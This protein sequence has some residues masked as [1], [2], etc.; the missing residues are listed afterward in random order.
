MKYAFVFLVVCIHSILTYGQPLFQFT[1]VVNYSKQQYGAGTQNWVVEQDRFG[2]MYFANNEGVLTYNGNEWQV[3]PLPNNTIVRYIAFGIDGKLYAGGQDELGYYEADRLG[4][5]VFTSL[6]HL[7]NKDDRQFA[8][9]WNILPQGNEVFFRSSSRIFWLHNGEIS[10]FKP[11]SSWTFLGKHGKYIMAHDRSTG[12]FVFKNGRWELAFRSSKLPQDLKITSMAPFKFGSILT[13]EKNGLLRIIGNDIV[14]FFLKGSNI[15][16]KQ[17]FT[18]VLLMENHELL[19]GT[20]DDGIYHVDSVG[21]VLE[22]FSTN[23]GL[24]NN[25][26]KYIFR[27]A[28]KKIW[29]GLEDGISFLNTN[30]YVKFLRPKL[31]N[32]AAG[33]AATIFGEKLYFALANGIYSM[34]INKI[35]DYS[36]DIG[37]LKKLTDGLS[38]KV[39]N[40]QGHLFAGCEDGFFEIKGDRLIPIDRSTGYWVFEYINQNATTMSLATGSYLGVSF[41]QSSSGVYSRQPD[42]VFLNSSSRYLEYDSSQNVVWVSHPYRGIYKISLANKSAKLYTAKDGLPAALNNH[43][44]TINKKI[45]IATVNGVYRFNPLSERFE[46][47]TVYERI[48]NGLSIRYLAEDLKGNLWFVHDKDIGVVDHSNHSITFF[49]EMR[50][51]ILSGFEHVSP[52]DSNHVLIG[53]TEGFFSINYE[54]YVKNAFAPQVYISNVIAKNVK[55]SLLYGGFIN[56]GLQDAQEITKLSYKWKS[57]HFD[58][59]SPYYEQSENIAYSYFLKGFDKDWSDWTKKTGKDYTNLPP[60]KYQF[61]VKA[62]NNLN[63]E[64]PVAAYSFVIKPPWYSTVFSWFMYG[65]IL[66]YGL[67]KLWKRQEN[68]LKEKQEL[69]IEA[70]RRKFEEEQKL[71]EGIHQ[72]ELEKSEK[73]FIKLRNEKLESEIEFKNAELASMAMNMVQKKEFLIKLKDELNRLNKS[74]KEAV[75]TSELKKIIRSL[76]N[77]DNLDEEWEQFSIHF[78]KVHGDFL[79]KLKNKFPD[80]KAHELKLCA[81]LR[82][83]LS[84]KEIAHLMSISVRGVEISRYRLRKK[85]QV[86]SK[87]DLFQFLFN[88]E[89]AE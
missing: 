18:S 6:K 34:P 32:N 56:N 84:S 67:F 3:F 49:P 68:K 64:S 39:S 8:D 14:P 1:R 12:L 28:N 35:G 88:L 57:F 87:I 10:V 37:R 38:W 61:Q 48:F 11:K 41:Y 60:G 36:K 33:Y 62:R 69:K 73:E 82:M 21:N 51:R 76:T 58:F 40:V 29:L 79:R 17:F 85:L 20:Y 26:V 47:D 78:N 27:D 59:S 65:L 77:E 16:T 31:F 42:S 24:I 45:V 63:K 15:S 25:N 52:I 80:L 22:K 72:L 2:R 70:E 7:I 44:F 46:V 19:I 54:Q 55:D 53:G 43:V 83:N 50:R 66:I 13:T 89:N 5:F 74:G 30:S 75:D 9:I 81:Y 4:R 86:P 71:L 23:E